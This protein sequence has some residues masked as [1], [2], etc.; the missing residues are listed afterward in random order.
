MINVDCLVDACFLG[1]GRRLPYLD[2]MGRVSLCLCLQALEE[3]DTRLDMPVQYHRLISYV[4]GAGRSTASACTQTR[5]AA[6]RF[7]SSHVSQGLPPGS[8]LYQT[9]W[10]FQNVLRLWEMFATA[11]HDMSQFVVLYLT[12]P[13]HLPGPWPSPGPS[14]FVRTGH[15]RCSWMGCCA[16]GGAEPATFS[17]RMGN[18]FVPTECKPYFNFHVALETLSGCIYDLDQ[19]DALWGTS[20]EEWV[21]HIAWVEHPDGRMEQTVGQTQFKFIEHPIH[22]QDPLKSGEYSWEREVRYSL[23]TASYC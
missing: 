18:A 7:Q 1:H 16:Q 19:G 20:F 8:I 6:I 3:F 10:C 23:L 12:M 14:R 5:T 17:L 2:S 15:M 13:A 11:G 22:R 9:Q 21:R 4:K